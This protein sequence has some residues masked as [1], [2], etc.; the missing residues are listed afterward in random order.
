[1]RQHELEADQQRAGERGELERRL[2]ARARRRRRPRRPRGATSSTLLERRAG[3]AGRAWYCRQSQ[4]ENGE[5][6]PSWKPNVRSQK[7]RAACSGFGSSRRIENA[8]SGRAS[9]AERRT[10][11]FARGRRARPGRRP[12]AATSSSAAN[13]VQ[14]ASATE[15]AARRRRRDEPEAP[16]QERAAGSRRSCSSSTTYCVNGY[17]AQANASVAAEPRAAE[18][19]AR[20]APS[21]SRHEQVEQ[22]SSVKCAAGRSSHFPRP[23][24]R[25]G[26][27]A[28][29]RGRRPGR[30][31]RRAGS[32]V[33]QRPFVWMRSRISPSASAAPHAFRSSS[34]GMCPYGDSP[35]RDPLRADHARVA[36]VDHVRV[37]RRSGRRGSRPRKTRRRREQPDRP[38][39]ARAVAAAGRARPIQT[40]RPSR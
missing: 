21:P 27:R 31:C 4:I 15:R 14:P 11:R 3:R 26:S 1:M 13:F 37:A 8:S 18:A 22:R 35:V 16:D 38:D 5:S 30:T 39:R 36:D 6:R 33:S 9:E 20:R 23:A 19:P 12:R 17:A 29:R 28:G 32:R 25:P 40:Q 7:T 24:E 34:T 2:P 10:R